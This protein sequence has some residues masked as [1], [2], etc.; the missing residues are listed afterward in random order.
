MTTPTSIIEGL[1]T[2]LQTYTSLEEDA[3]VWVDYLGAVPTEYS[4]FP[5]PGNKIIESYVNGGSLREFPFS[6]QSVEST[7][8]ELT[9]M[10]SIGFFEAFA[11]WLESQTEVGDLPEL[12]SKKTAVGIEATSW[13]FLYEQGQ[14]DSGIYQINARLIYEQQP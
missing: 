7:S 10:E 5:M 1:R 2:F 3:P 13:G 11:D 9:R 6:F 14:S 8:D 12:P 4:I